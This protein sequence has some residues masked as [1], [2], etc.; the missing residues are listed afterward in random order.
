MYSGT[1]ITLDI[2][3][4]EHYSVLY[5]HA[6]ELIQSGVLGEIRHIRARWHRNNT[7]PDNDGWHPDI[8]DLRDYGCQSDSIAA[9]I[10]KISKEL[11]KDAELAYLTD[12][13]K[14][15]REQNITIDTTQI[16]FNTKLGH[17]LPPSVVWSL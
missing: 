8:P 9:Q 17:K 10:K 13:L 1:P 6:V 14:E 4:E 16:F 7:W 2:T 3:G 5:D 15:E 12:Q 11:G